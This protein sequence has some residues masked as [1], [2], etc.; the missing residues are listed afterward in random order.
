MSSRPTGFKQGYIESGRIPLGR[1]AEPP[2]LA[3]AISHLVSADNTYIT[4]ARIMVDGGVTV[5]F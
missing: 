5:G 1:A 2:E 3:A 4:G